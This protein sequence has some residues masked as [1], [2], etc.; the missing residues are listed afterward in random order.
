ML[1]YFL[2]QWFST[3]VRPRPGKFFFIRWPGIIDARAWYRAT[4]WRLRNTVL[5]SHVTGGSEVVSIN[6]DTVICLTFIIM[7]L[8]K[9]LFE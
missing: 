3:F 4:A 9:L 2:D 5:D 7:I 8:A 6:S 1:P